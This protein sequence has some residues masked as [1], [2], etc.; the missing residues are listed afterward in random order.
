MYLLSTGDPIALH[1]ISMYYEEA[2]DENFEAGEK[3]RGC[4]WGISKKMIQNNVRPTASLF[5]HQ[6]DNQT[7]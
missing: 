1:K 2:N 6:N 7:T 5:K 3:G 4:G